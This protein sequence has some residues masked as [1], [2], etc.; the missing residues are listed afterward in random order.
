[1]HEE[2]HKVKSSPTTQLVSRITLSSGVTLAYEYDKEERITSVVESYIVDGFPV[3]TYTAYTYD[4]LGQ[5]LTETVNG[6]LINKLEYDNYGNIKKKN[7]KEYIYDRVW[8]DQ[9]IQIGYG[10]NNTI[11]YDAQGNPTTYL[12]HT[13][14]WEKG[15]QLKSFDSNTYTYNANGIRTSKTVNGVKHTYVL[16]GTKILSETWDD[17]TLVPMY[18]NEDSVCGIIYR[19]IPYYFLKNQQ[20]DVIS[21]SCYVNGVFQVV[22][23]YSYDAWGVCDI[24]SDISGRDIA[25]INPFR[26]RGYYY[27]REV[28]LYYLQSRYYDANVS[29]FVHGDDIDCINVRG[30]SNDNN[31]FNYCRNA[32]ITTLDQYGYF[33]TPIQWIFATVGAV[34]G[35]FLGDFIAKKLGYYSGWKYWAIRVGVIIGGAVIGWFAAKLLT[36]ILQ[37]FL[38]SHKVIYNKLPRL[39]K[40]FLGLKCFVAGT[41]VATSNG[42]QKIEEIK[43]GDSVL[44]YDFDTCRIT[45]S[46]V[47]ETYVNTATELTHVWIDSEEIIST[48]QHKY[49]TNNRGWISAVDLKETDELIAEDGS[50]VCI[51]RLY[52]EKLDVP[53]KVYNLNVGKHHNYF[54]SMR[55]ILV[56]NLGCEDVA[57]NSLKKISKSQIK[58]LGGEKVTSAIKKTYGGSKANLYIGSDGSVYVSVNGSK[59]AQWVGT[60][61]TLAEMYL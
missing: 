32:P 16:D 54:V 47:M 4:E 46:T 35:W 44:V 50:T 56:H 38:D 1:M 39:A 11:A 43:V 41:L 48:P 34:A 37:A 2:E 9:L 17:N 51:T 19:N 23:R 25:N 36:K 26:Y 53:V 61:E 7:N 18:D 52:T 33:G 30:T 27:D 59:I 57:T 45:T 58:Q 55:G 20:G 6:T 40:K 31:I 60:I 13:L 8:K 15:R 10:E 22:A 12:G 24:V 5:L 49:Y 28:G 14:T 29:R 21:I 42:Y 3:S